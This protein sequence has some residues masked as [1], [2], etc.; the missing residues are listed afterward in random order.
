MSPAQAV[1][2]RSSKYQVNI[3]SRVLGINRHMSSEDDISAQLC[4]MREAYLGLQRIYPDHELL[5]LVRVHQDKFEFDFTP[6]YNGRCEKC[7]DERAIYGF[8]R[9]TF[10]LEDAVRGKKYRLVDTDPPC[11]F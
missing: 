9:Y 6:E 4:I 2:R 3:K 10:A 5:K 11:D 7:R 1:C 8:T